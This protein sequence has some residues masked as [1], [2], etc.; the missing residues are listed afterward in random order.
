[1]RNRSS[2]A[3]VA[4]GASRKRRIAAGAGV[5]ADRAAAAR[6]RM[7]ELPLGTPLRDVLITA[8]EALG[9][10]GNYEFFQTREAQA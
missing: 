10:G 7:S 3:G 4:D 8:I 1:M 6:R 9:A 2:V 5:A